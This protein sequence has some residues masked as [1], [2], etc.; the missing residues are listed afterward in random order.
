MVH[1]LQTKAKR[2][3]PVLVLYTQFG[4]AGQRCD[5]CVALCAFLAMSSDYGTAEGTSEGRL[6]EVYLV[7]GLLPFC[8]FLL[9]LL[10]VV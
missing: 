2:S 10:E 8:I 3:P 4:L 5:L 6:G 9:L 7:G 1:H